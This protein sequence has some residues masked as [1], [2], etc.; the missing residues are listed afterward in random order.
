[1]PISGTH[2]AAYLEQNSGAANVIL[3]E[4]EINE[5]DAVVVIGEREIELATTGPTA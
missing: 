2:R 5:L 4:S 1:V 3:T